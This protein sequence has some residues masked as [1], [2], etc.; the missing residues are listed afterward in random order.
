MALLTYSIIQISEIRVKSNVVI[1][2]AS[3]QIVKT[4]TSTIPCVISVAQVVYVGLAWKIYQEFGWKV[5]HRHSS[6]QQPSDHPDSLPQVYKLLG[7][8]R[9]VKK[10][11]AHYLFY[12]CL[13]KFDGFFW[14]G[15]SIQAGLVVSGRIALLTP[16]PVPRASSQSWRRRVLPH[17]GHDARLFPG[18]ARWPPGSAPR[19]QMD[20][21]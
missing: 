12:E 13:I 1:K 4:L 6:P 14:V 2:E 3:Q 10:M 15:F 16:K 18:P 11:Y 9:L 17:N 20:D 8:D 19:K 21:D 5:C 7:A